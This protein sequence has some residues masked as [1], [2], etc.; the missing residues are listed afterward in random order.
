MTA[1]CRLGG[2]AR[3]FARLS[4]PGIYATSIARPSLFR[5]YL[6]EQ[7]EHLQR[8]YGVDA[9]RSA[10]RRAKFPIPM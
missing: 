5:D 1:R 7:L 8:D 2:S 6:I 3:A 10:A 9:F 4:E